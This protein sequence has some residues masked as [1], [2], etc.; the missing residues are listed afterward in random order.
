ME[1]D[2]AQRAVRS[3]RSELWRILKIT[4]AISHSAAAV[5][6]V[7]SHISDGIT[8]AATE[9][10]MAP[11]DLAVGFSILGAPW[12]LV[13]YSVFEYLRPDNVPLAVTRWWGARI[14][15]SLGTTTLL[16]VVLLWWWA[17]RKRYTR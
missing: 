3:P 12:S 7:G 17:L 16:N 11:L 5:F 10:G 1:R 2:Q 13:V 4:L 14:I 15:L 9:R 8:Y 6:V